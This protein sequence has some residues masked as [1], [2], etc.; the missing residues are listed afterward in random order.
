VTI[1][2]AG[3]RASLPRDEVRAD[4]PIPGVP[5]RLL[6]PGGAVVE[7]A[8]RAA[9]E[10]VWPT[11]SRIDRAAWW[12]ESRASMALVALAI[13]AAL[14]WVL[15]AEVLPFAADPVARSIGPETEEAIGR[16]VLDSL[17][18]L[19]T[20]PSRLP[21]DRR[22]ELARAF[23]ALVQGDADDVELAFRRMGS[24]NAFALPGRRIVLTDEMV[25]FARSDDEILAVLAHE[26]G[27]VH[28]RHAMRLVLQQSG[29]AVLVT[30]LAG[31][32]VGMTILAVVVPAALLNARYSRAFELEADRYALALLA[33]H[34]HS[35][36]S[37]IDVLR[38]FAQDERTAG[39][40]DPLSRYLSSHPDLDERIRR[41]ETAQ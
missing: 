20:Q 37:F 33:R 22:A 5:R 6:L 35:A 41:A 16:Q 30:A 10:A 11:R 7:T 25:A 2:C 29:V 4:R 9:V 1:V 24:P 14:V 18:A 17:D 26:A 23:A 13:T 31:D 12:L 21:E 40:R 38:R 39:A 27:H 15:I 28:H 32:A 19:H 8:D 3:V 34:G 36:Q